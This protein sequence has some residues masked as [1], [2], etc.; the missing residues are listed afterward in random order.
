MGELKSLS[1][2]ISKLST[3]QRRG[4]R[5]TTP[6]PARRFKGA[7]LSAWFMAGIPSPQIK[8]KTYRGPES[9]SK[10]PQLL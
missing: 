10:M 5:D 7:R 3:R 1:H 9:V 6:L 4:L 8:K 2:S